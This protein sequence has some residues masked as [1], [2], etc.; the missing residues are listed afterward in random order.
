M[1]RFIV[2]KV[3]IV[4]RNSMIAGNPVTRSFTKFGVYDRN[5]QHDRWC[6]C[7]RPNGEWSTNNGQSRKFRLVLDEEA[8]AKCV[9]DKLNELSKSIGGDTCQIEFGVKKPDCITTM[10]SYMSDEDIRS[11]CI[12]KSCR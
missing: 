2:K 12:T 3:K 6:C 8:K 4:W 11:I 10:R 1:K 7:P 5:W 9:A